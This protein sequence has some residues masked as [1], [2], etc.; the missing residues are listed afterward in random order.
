MPR[1]VAVAACLS[2]LLA[3]LMGGCPQSSSSSPDCQKCGRGGVAPSYSFTS[4]VDA[5]TALH[6]EA[7]CGSFS[8]D[9]AQG[10]RT[11]CGR[12][13]TCDG[14]LGCRPKPEC[15]VHL[16]DCPD[17]GMGCYPLGTTAVCDP[18]GTGGDGA[19][20]AVP[21]DCQPGMM[22]QLGQCTMPCDE[23][24]PCP[25]TLQCWRLACVPTCD[26]MAQDCA[27]SANGTP[28]GCY[29]VAPPGSPTQ[30]AC[31]PAGPKTLG[32]TC[33]SGDEC[34]RG[35]DCA[36][37][38][39]SFWCLPRCQQPSD[40]AGPGAACVDGFCLS[41]CSP[42]A[43]DCATGLSC[44]VAN[45][46]APTISCLQGGAKLD[47]YSCGSGEL[48]QGPLQCL[49]NQCRPVCTPGTPCPPVEITVGTMTPRECLVFN[50]DAGLAAC[51]V[52]CSP[53]DQDCTGYY[54]GCFPMVPGDR[55]GICGAAGRHLCGD[56]CTVD[57]DCDVARS[58][59]LCRGGQCR[60]ACNSARACAM[61]TCSDV[62]GDFGGC[63]AC[64]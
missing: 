61:G 39:S 19:P 54:S 2:L 6:C 11:T 12:A 37:Y 48:C 60:T 58:H 41:A 63:S 64:P 57:R 5:Q 8:C 1:V 49:E 15:N 52:R 45:E 43:Q 38:S 23:S 42:S 35:L 10:S 26:A 25:G 30:F 28:M 29:N 33:S 55:G 56:P 13:M 18:V 53:A 40:C 17:A 62:T 20:C 46:D 4:C 31:L 9:Y 34:A 51:G 44:L 22:C 27:P 3:A 32:Q 50:A 16:Q 24:H 14:C 47:G 21:N 7:D 36:E 59:L